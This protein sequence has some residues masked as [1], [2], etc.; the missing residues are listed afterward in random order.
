MRERH[1]RFIKTCAGLPEEGTPPRSAPNIIAVNREQQTGRC[2]W[3]TA[4]AGGGSVVRCRCSVWPCQ[5]AA[6]CQTAL[7]GKGQVAHGYA[8]LPRKLPLLCRG[9]LNMAEILDTFVK[10]APGHLPLGRV[11]T[12]YFE[13]STFAT[14]QQQVGIIEPLSSN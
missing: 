11:E 12:V 2:V 14:F 1:Y 6:N 10:R 9:I 4:G 13:N 8:S 7:G 5:V 3:V